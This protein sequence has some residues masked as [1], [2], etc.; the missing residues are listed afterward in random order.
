[1]Q[2]GRRQLLDLGV[3]AVELVKECLHGGDAGCDR[4]LRRALGLNFDCAAPEH[5]EGWDD[6]PF[7]KLF[8]YGH[9][10]SPDVGGGVEVVATIADAAVGV[11]EIPILE[12]LE[13]CADIRTRDG[14]LL[15]DVFC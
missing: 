6:L 8:D 14:E 12:F 10:E 2:A 3:P 4:G 15:C 13:A 1:M 9:E 11:D 7:D 5:G